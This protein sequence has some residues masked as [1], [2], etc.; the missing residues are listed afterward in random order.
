VSY[1]TPQYTPPADRPARPSTVTVATI[2]L[3]LMAALSVIAAVLNAIAASYQTADAIKK[4]YLA[5]GASTAEADA[6]ATSG[7]ITGY[8]T[9]AFV[10]IFGVLYLILAIFTGK[11]QN[12]ARI[13]TWVVGGLG[14]CCGVANLA[15]QALLTSML[16]NVDAGYDLEAV[17]KNLAALPPSWLTSVS[18]A[19]GLCSLVLAI[20]A[21]VCLTLPPSHPYFRKQEPVW[22]PPAGPAV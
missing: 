2:S 9:A 10:L 21:V 11:G 15:G 6:A 4:I 1:V 14:I 12:W 18:L 13:V 19:L 22:V 8:V 3:F 16:K 17:T 20:V 7:P 5:A